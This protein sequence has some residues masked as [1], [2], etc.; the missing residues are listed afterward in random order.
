MI[1]MHKAA[2]LIN[3]FFMHLQGN[4]LSMRIKEEWHKS[5]RRGRMIWWNRLKNKK[6]YFTYSLQKKIKIN[7]YFDSELC[8][9]IYCDNFEWS[10]RQFFNN[11][12]KS[13]DVFVDIGANIGL[14]TLIASHHVG[15]KGKVY[16]FEPCLKTFQRLI[17]NTQLNNM[18]NVQC[19]RVALSDHRGRMQMN[20]SL[21]G[22]D[23]WNSIGKPTAGRLFTTETVDVIMWDHFV[24]ENNL[25]GRVTM[26]KIDVEGWESRILSGGIETLKRQDA[27]VLQIEF[28]D[29]ASQSAG[30]TCQALYCQLEELGYQMYIY[31]EKV[32]QIIPDPIRDSY[33]YLN[34]LATKHPDDINARLKR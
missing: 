1:N 17:Q 3:R 7:L 23:A 19:M 18:K 30:T 32:K 28:T 16:S 27:P 11:Y 14:F 12:L 5:I 24:H 9:L 2:Y 34:L 8:R 6:E 21:D 26:M 20:V 4:T 25:A 22:Y 29:Q 31:N 13:G 10:E 33:P 15:N